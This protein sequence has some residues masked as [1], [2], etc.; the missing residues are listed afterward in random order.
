MKKINHIILILTGKEDNNLQKLVEDKI[1]NYGITLEFRF[2]SLREK[3]ALLTPK[4]L[5]T[6][7][8]G[9]E[10]YLDRFVVCKS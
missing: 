10:F 2:D 3:P 1:K 7:E 4:G 8:K 6:G 9:I 5:F